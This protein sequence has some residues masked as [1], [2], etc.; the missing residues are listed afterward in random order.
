MYGLTSQI[1][2]AALSI[3][4]N[5]VEGYARKGDKELARFVN[6]AMGSLAETEYLLEFSTK[7]GYLKAQD[8]GRLENLRA[9][10]GKLLWSFY[11]KVG[12]FEG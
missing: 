2:R 7:L 6:I 10:V 9:E 11:K 4:T 5:I 1:R 3:P 12:G 8:F